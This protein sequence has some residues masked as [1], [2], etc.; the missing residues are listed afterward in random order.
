M[1]F[2]ETTGAGLLALVDFNYLN[3]DYSCLSAYSM[4]WFYDR[5][6]IP[7]H[8]QWQT[9]YTLVPVRDVFNCYYA[10]ARVIVTAARDDKFALEFRATDQP[11]KELG[12]TVRAETSDRNRKLAEVSRR[13]E[14]LQRDKAQVLPVPVAN[15]REKPFIVSLQVGGQQTEFMFSADDS[16]YFAP[17]SVSIYRAP[18]PR[19]QKPELALEDQSVSLAKHE[20]FSVLYAI[21]LWHEFNRVKE[22]LTALDSHVQFRDTYYRSNF[23]GPEL[24]YQPLLAKE[25]LGYDLIVLNNVGANALGEAGEIAVSR[26]VKAGGSLLLCGGFYT[27]GRGR[28]NEG[29]LADALPVVVD[30]FFDLQPLPR[31]TPLEP[32]T[33]LGSVEWIQSVKDVKPGATVRLT[34]GGK[35]ALVTGNY[36]KGKVAVWLGTPMGDPPPGATPY[37]DSPQWIKFLIGVLHDLRPAQP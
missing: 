10:D 21:G 17:E 27:M 36:G 31:F 34:A 28:F 3:Y 18:V 5:V 2:N 20:T 29:P 25:L 32:N 16:L 11:V 24:T 19:K 1:T 30:G 37:W 6:L 23:L 8:E 14:N 26:Y 15:W 35:P 22:A 4:E 9:Q 7:A 13:L 33:G 12:V